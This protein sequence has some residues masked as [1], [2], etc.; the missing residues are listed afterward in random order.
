MRRNSLPRQ[1]LIDDDLIGALRE[2]AL[3]NKPL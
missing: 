3:R 1:I 2:N